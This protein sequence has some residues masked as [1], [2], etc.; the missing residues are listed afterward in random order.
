MLVLD[1]LDD[2][3]L[4]KLRDSQAEGGL[5]ATTV[6][7]QILPTFPMQAQQYMCRRRLKTRVFTSHRFGKGVQHSYHNSCRRD[8]SS[9]FIPMASKVR[10]LLLDIHVDVTVH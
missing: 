1:F 10:A 5:K 9:R 3:A 8:G 6:L 4:K 7:I 2:N